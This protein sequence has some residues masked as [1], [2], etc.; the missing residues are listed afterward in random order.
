MRK[1]PALTD[2]DRLR[3]AWITVEVTSGL[4]R[5]QARHGN[6]FRVRLEENATL[7]GPTEPH[8]GQEI[9]LR[10]EQ[11]GTGS[12]TLTVNAAGFVTRGSLPT[13]ISTAASAVS[14]LRMVY[15]DEAELWELQGAPDLSAVYQPLDSDLTAIAALATTTFG[16]SLLTVADAA[17]GRA[18]LIA[19]S[20]THA[21]GHLPGGSD[22][23]FTAGDPFVITGD[24]TLRSFDPT[25][26][27]TAD[28]ANIV[29]TMLRDMQANKYPRVA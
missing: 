2:A 26:V 16:R 19:A 10:V 11:D 20:T 29:A 3:D 4:V 5:I 6:R 1:T 13:L 14:Y 21:S 22:Q 23:V 9:I 15:D 12:R 28:L 17:A 24:A 27:T 7:E 18:A 8:P 25:T